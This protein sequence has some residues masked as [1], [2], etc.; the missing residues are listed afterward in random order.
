[1]LNFSQILE[2]WKNHL[3]PD[4]EM[5]AT[6]NQISKE[7]LNI[8]KTCPF[9]STPGNIT[10]VS[11]C[12]ACGCLLKA[13]SKCLSCNCGIEKY[14]EENPDEPLELKWNSVTTKENNIHIHVNLNDDAK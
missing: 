9:N 7:R 14:N 6:I 2:G 12:K 3:I 8:C 4:K 5:I 11:R 1:M 13:K 10:V